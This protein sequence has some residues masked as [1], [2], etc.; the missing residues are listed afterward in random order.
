M[1]YGFIIAT[2]LRTQD[3]YNALNKNIIIILRYYSFDQIVVIV[4]FTSDRG[5]V[6]KIREEDE[7]ILFET[8]TPY[9]PAEMLTHYYFYKKHY[10]DTAIILQDS[11]RILKQ[12]DHIDEVKDV[13]YLWHF[14]NHRREWAIIK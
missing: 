8:D 12:F 14:T 3:H 4:D 5:L 7:H 13:Q 1:T 2:C 6:D 11:M 10:F 9:T